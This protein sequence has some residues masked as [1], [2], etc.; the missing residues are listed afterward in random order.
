[1]EITGVTTDIL[2]PIWIQW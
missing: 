2:L 1:M